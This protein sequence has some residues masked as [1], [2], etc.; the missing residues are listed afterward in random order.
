MPLLSPRETKLACAW[1]TFICY[2]VMMILSYSIGQK[3][4][5]IP[6][7]IKK[8]SSYLILTAVLFFAQSF[9]A[10]QLD[11]LFLKIVPFYFS[12]IKIT[13]DVA[14]CYLSP[15]HLPKPQKKQT[16]P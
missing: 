1:T 12:Y 14:S 13:K 5:P 2:A 11:A 7:A 16:Y 4:Y 9:I 8:I 10:H 3:H 15:A 6:Y